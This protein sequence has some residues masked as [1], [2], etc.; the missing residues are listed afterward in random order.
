MSRPC[1]D[2][3][4]RTRREPDMTV[5]AILQRNIVFNV[6]YVHFTSCTLAHRAA[7]GASRPIDRTVIR[8]DPVHSTLID[9]PS[10]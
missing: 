4:Y 3:K 9:A 7:H 6:S 1:G 2:T 5:T 10:L 8:P